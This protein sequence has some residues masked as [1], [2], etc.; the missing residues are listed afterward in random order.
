MLKDGDTD[1]RRFEIHDMHFGITERPNMNLQIKK[2]IENVKVLLANG[3]I[4][5]D[6]DVKDNQLSGAVPNTKYL[7]PDKNDTGS[8]PAVDNIGVLH[9]EMDSE[10]L[11]GAT[12]QITYKFT[13]LNTSELDYNLELPDEGEKTA[14]TNPNNLLNV[15]YKFGI[16]EDVSEDVSKEVTMTAT[17][18]V[19]Y[20]DNKLNYE[21]T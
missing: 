11:H 6:A 3:N 17:K 7:K 8:G 19:D 1:S 5:I 10:L 2:E 13:I 20:M 9:M 4:L 14:E 18:V 21:K 16:Y 15:Y 12:V